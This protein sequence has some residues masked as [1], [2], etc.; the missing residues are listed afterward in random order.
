MSN[1]RELVLLVSQCLPF[2]FR[3]TQPNML[4]HRPRS[5]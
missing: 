5:L 3:I 4:V 2:Q 1:S